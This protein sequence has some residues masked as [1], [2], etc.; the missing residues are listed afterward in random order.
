MNC[1][2]CNSTLK[3]FEL[4]AC[5][6]EYYDCP[7]YGRTHVCD[8]Y[9]T[10]AVA[11]GHDTALKAMAADLT[12]GYRGKPWSLE[13]SRHLRTLYPGHDDW[14]DTKYQI[15]EVT[16]LGVTNLISHICKGA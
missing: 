9:E 5:W 2:T 15:V 6:A 8:T 14:R 4:R 11:V 12:A 1:P 7:D 10:V 13:R 3:L 16:K